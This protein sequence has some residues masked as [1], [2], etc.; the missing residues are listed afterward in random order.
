MKPL[1][2]ASATKAE[3]GLYSG[4]NTKQNAR[5]TWN[6]LCNQ[7]LNSLTFDYGRYSRGKSLGAKNADR[8]RFPSAALVL[9][10]FEAILTA[11]SA[12]LWTMDK[13]RVDLTQ[14]E[15]KHNL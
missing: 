13:P 6:V 12:H 8:M 14:S 2:N 15:I 5:D 9:G 7:R 10:H 3:I 1:A 11:R 4:K